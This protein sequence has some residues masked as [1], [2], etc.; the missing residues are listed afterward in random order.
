[1]FIHAVLEPPWRRC[2]VF[3]MSSFDPNQ[4]DPRWTPRPKPAPL[5]DMTVT[6]E[7]VEGTQRHQIPPVPAK[8]MGVAILVTALAAAGA[9]ALLALWFVLTLI[10]ILIG[11][12][13]IAFAVFRVQLWWAR[14][15]SLGGQRNVF[16][17]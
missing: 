4:S 6:G 15:K 12:G 5:I 10:P 8:I 17:P 16:R 14:R 13:L 9:I 1:M 3:R 11:A 2:H 7:F